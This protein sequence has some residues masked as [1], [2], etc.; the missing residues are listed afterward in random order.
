MCHVIP[1]ST[2]LCNS[3][4]LAIFDPMKKI[5]F[6]L[7]LFLTLSAALQAQKRDRDLE[8]LV[9]YMQGGFTSA[10]QAAVDTNYYDISLHMARIWTGRTDGCW[11][12]VEQAVTKML[13]KPYRQRVYH[14]VH[15]ADGSFESAVYTLPD[16]KA[17]IGAWKNP[18]SLDAVKMEDILVRKGCAV[19]LKKEGKTFA[20]ATNGNDC[21]S[22]LRG[23]KYATSKVTI[24]K[25]GINSWDQGF[26]AAG[27][28]VWGAENG[29]YLFVKE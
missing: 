12:Y 28:Q 5:L 22:N 11:L 19:I 17:A 16:E 13:D 29:P 18:A 2:H 4:K 24:T 25:K 15:Q 9:K 1:A 23:A 8:T 27:N 20:G 26:D 7:K 14:V 3:S 6:T 10:A 21:E